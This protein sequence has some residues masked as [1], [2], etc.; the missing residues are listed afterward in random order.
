MVSCQA[1]TPGEVFTDSSDKAELTSF[2]RDGRAAS[3]HQDFLI[4]KEVLV[5]LRV[6][7]SQVYWDLSIH[8][9]YSFLNPISPQSMLSL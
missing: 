7:Y 1:T 6:Q 9:H 5:N 8:L 4:G 2:D 3:I